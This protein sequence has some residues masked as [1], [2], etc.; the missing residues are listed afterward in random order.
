M[1]N[2]NILSAKEARE[3]A[4]SYASNEAQE[5]IKSIGEEIQKLANDG[6]STLFISEMAEGWFPYFDSYVK[7]FFENLGYKVSC[8]YG[9]I[10]GNYWTISW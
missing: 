2:I 7:R 3:I 4:N 1:F 10:D 6:N 8:H 9:G 5:I